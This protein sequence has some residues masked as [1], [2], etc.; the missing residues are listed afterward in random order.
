MNSIATLS[1]LVVTRIELFKNVGAF[2]GFHAGLREA[3][4]TRLRHAA[5][6]DSGNQGE[7][8]DAFLRDFETLAVLGIGLKDFMV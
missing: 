5:R 3:T 4:M 6:V 8:H 2:W 7:G 1:K